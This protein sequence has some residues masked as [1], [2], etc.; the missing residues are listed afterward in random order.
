MV[1]RLK[2]FFDE[3]LDAAIKSNITLYLKPPPSNSEYM[4]KY[5]GIF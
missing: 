2:I 5:L 4:V 3:I 1:I